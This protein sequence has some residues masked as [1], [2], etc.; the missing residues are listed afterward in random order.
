MKVGDEH[1]NDPIATYVPELVEMCNT[2]V[3]EVVYN[4]FDKVHWNEVTLG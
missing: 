1:F 3:T 2:S 4:D